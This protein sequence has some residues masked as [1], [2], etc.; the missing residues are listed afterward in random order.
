MLTDYFGCDLSPADIAGYT[1][2]YTQDGLVLWNSLN[3][4]C[5]VFETRR[6]G[7]NDQAIKTSLKDPN[8]AVMLQVN[9]GE[10][11]VVALR[12]T[13][14][15]NSYI[16]ADPWTGQKC[17]VLKVYKNITGSSHFNRRV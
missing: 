6:Q 7:R 10:H 15:G 2:F 16:V 17:D 14:F 4:K 5:M 11:W 12:S 9:D 8:K 1:S 13:L 3:F